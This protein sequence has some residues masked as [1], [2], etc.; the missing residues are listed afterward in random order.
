MR[1]V[2]NGLRNYSA[3]VSTP[4]F[5]VSGG[6][7]TGPS[8]TYAVPVRKWLIIGG[9]LALGAVV[10]VTVWLTRSDDPHDQVHYLGTQPH[11]YATPHDA[12]LAVCHARTASLE[13]FDQYAR[14]DTY[15][16]F[17]LADPLVGVYW[18][19][20]REPHQWLAVVS[21]VGSRYTVEKCRA[22]QI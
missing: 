15:K 3:G 6:G 10:A 19:P 4:W 5:D 2:T 18:I 12:V 16:A 8:P 20:Q 1:A 17:H 22:F 13:Q 21:P 7:T 9:A 11:L 14:P